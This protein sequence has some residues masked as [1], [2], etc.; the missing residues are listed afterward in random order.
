M[1]GAMPGEMRHDPF[2][3]ETQH[4]L[5]SSA[6]QASPGRAQPS[7]LDGRGG[8]ERRAASDQYPCELRLYT[9]GAG[10][11]ANNLTLSQHRADAVKD[12]LVAVF[13]VPAD[14]LESVGRGKADMANPGNP[15]DAVNRRVLIVN[16]DRSPTRRPEPSLSGTAP[17][18]IESL[19]NGRLKAG[20]TGSRRRESFDIKELGRRIRLSQG[21]VPE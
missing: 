6:R 2:G 13:D 10:S 11:D 9:D 15:L 18:R 3:I 7:R 5:R 17:Q 1:N 19:R 14:H 4:S 21:G 12:F 8:R 20:T 16:E